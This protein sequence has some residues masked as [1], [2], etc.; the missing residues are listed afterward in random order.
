MPLISQMVSSLDT[1]SLRG[2]LLFGGARADWSRV[3]DEAA[4]FRRDDSVLRVLE[5]EARREE[6]RRARERCRLWCMPIPAGA[7]VGRPHIFRAL[8]AKN[9]GGVSGAS[10]VWLDADFASVDG[11]SGKLQALIDYVDTTHVASQP[12]SANQCSMPQPDALMGSAKSAD[13]VGVNWY[14]SSRQSTAFRYH[15]GSGFDACCSLVPGGQYDGAI[16]ATCDVVSN[17]PGIYFGLIGT[18]LTP[19]D[20]IGMVCNAGTRIVQAMSAGQVVPTA[21]SYISFSYSSSAAPQY[22]TRVKETI[23]QSGSATG[24]PTTNNATSTLTFGKQTGSP[25]LILTAR[26]RAIYIHRRVLNAA[27]RLV[28]QAFIRRDTGIAP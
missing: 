7:S 13:F 2:A 15:D 1:P 12:S 3:F 17:L 8:F 27:E 10:D 6:E 11:S 20:T 9:I 26:V 16:I 28:R 24:S 21:A 4:T 14:Q 5:A 23:A 19:R 22:A 18:T 25:S